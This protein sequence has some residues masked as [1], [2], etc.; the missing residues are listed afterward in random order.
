MSRNPLHSWFRRVSHRLPHLLLLSVVVALVVAACGGGEPTATPL[1]TATP[2]PTATPIVFPTPLPT[3]TPQPGVPTATPAPTAAPPTPQPTATPVPT[4]TPIPTAMPASPI[5]RGGTLKTTGG[6]IAHFDFQKAVISSPLIIYSGLV[7]D[8]GRE[9]LGADWE[10]ICDLCESFT[11]PNPTT[12]VFNIRQGVRFAPD[13]GFDISSFPGANG[14]EV[15]AD[16]LAFSLNRQKEDDSVWRTQLRK[17]ISIKALDKWTLE[18]VLA[19]ADIDFLQ[20][21]SNARSSV[22]AR[23]IVD[24]LGDLKEGPNVGSGPWVM[25]RGDI[26]KGFTYIRNPDYFEIGADGQN[27]PYMDALDQIVILDK[28][29]RLAAFRTGAIHFQTLTPDEAKSIRAAEPLWTY[30]EWIIPCP[31]RGVDLNRNVP[32]LDNKDFVRALF[33]AY[34]PLAG[35]ETIDSGLG[36]FFGAVTS[37]K[38][39]WMFELQPETLKF[40]ND[41][42]KAREFLAKSGVKTPID[43]NWFKYGSGDQDTGTAL[44]K[45]QFAKIGVNL[46]VSTGTIVEQ[47]ATYAKGKWG[48]VHGAFLPGIMT[49][50]PSRNLYVFSHSAGT[51]TKSYGI[52]DPVLDA[53]IDKQAVDTDPVSRKAT[54]FE[55]TFYMAENGYWRGGWARTGIFSANSALHN[56][57]PSVAFSPTLYLSRLWLDPQ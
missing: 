4:P 57:Y 18:I 38:P 25:T 32:P 43:L 1:P 50:P 13:M 12:L 3:A 53:L 15:T 29:T 23:E 40:V 21:Q 7:R 9:D 48:D 37:F 44:V 55:I 27:L 28:S 51:I 10:L 49:P 52:N 46:N 17:A 41:L 26:N 14:R 47:I 6:A 39:S 5:R 16:D 20:T 54:I 42:D 22:L 8:L 31:C 33:Y 45:E 56:Y 24:E 2:Q 34:D 36:V 35:I 11:S 19:D 30:N